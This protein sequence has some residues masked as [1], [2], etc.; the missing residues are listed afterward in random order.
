MFVKGVRVRRDR[1]EELRL[2]LAAE[3]LVDTTRAILDEDGFVLIPLLGI[4][5]D[6]LLSGFDAN[7]VEREFPM[8]FSRP[9]PIDQVRDALELPAELMRCLP[10]RWEQFGDVLVIRLPE[11]LDE[12]EA[13]VAA[14]YASVLRVK[15]VL[16]DEG[17]IRGTHR[18]P[19]VRIIHGTDPVTVHKE[20]GVL[21]KFDV[22]KIMFSSGNTDERVRAGRIRC[23]G[24]QIVDMFAGIGYFSI[25]LAV[26][27]RPR[28]V[29]ACE[30][31][32][33]SHGYLV[34]NIGLNHVGDVV[35]PFLGDNRSLEGE[36]FADR[37]FMGYVK[38]THEYLDTAF[39]LL[40]SGGIVHYHETCPCELLPD[41]PIDRVRAAF[42]EGDVEVLSLREVKSYSPGVSHVVVEARVFKDV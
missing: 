24:E 9:D 3:S 17:G 5:G 6:D 32:P 25:P 4:A 16:R 19:V 34:E 15:S 23:D 38:T 20:N 30:I 14:A 22:S 42:S 28:R 11:E 8:R 39:R 26:H 41:R 1:A 7:V 36:S 13:E 18:T 21:F 12:H 31:N 33:T 29:F 35:E 40:R 27:Q 10:T 2:R 37:I